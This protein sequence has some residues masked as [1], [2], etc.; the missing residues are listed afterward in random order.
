M[1]APWLHSA[2]CRSC[3]DPCISK[4]PWSHV[5]FTNWQSLSRWCPGLCV[6]PAREALDGTLTHALR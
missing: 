4:L 5:R 6:F 3:I 1:C 2:P